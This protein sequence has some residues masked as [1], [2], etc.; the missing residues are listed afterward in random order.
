M[1]AV[2]IV[3]AKHPSENAMAMIMAKLPA[4]WFANQPYVLNRTPLLK[5]EKSPHR[6]SAG[7]GSREGRARPWRASWWT[8]LL[9]G[10]SS[11]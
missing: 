8:P 6:C 5:L 10:G 11:V 1:K 2:A 9:G 4:R 7:A 3:P